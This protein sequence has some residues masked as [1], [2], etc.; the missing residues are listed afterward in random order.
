VTF[1]ESSG[2]CVNLVSSGTS[3]EESAFLDAS[4]SGGDVF[5][6][7]KARLVAQ[8]FDNALD[9][10]DA[11]EC[12]ASSPCIAPAPAPPPPCDNADSCKPAQSLQPTVFGAG[13][14]ETFSGAGNV[15]PSPPVVQPRKLTR[16]Q[17]LARALRVC[18]RVK[19]R[20]A[21]AA[22]VRRARRRYGARAA[23]GGRRSRG[24]QSAGTRR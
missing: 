15:T 5:F 13:P 21:H 1:S 19:G 24:S 8:D 23:R 14:S 11:H 4:R 12:A 17:Q 6:L 20:R 2:G 7:T 16:A 18:A 10:Y 22:C 9:V 3:N